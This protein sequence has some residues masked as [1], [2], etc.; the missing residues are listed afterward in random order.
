MFFEQIAVGQTATSRRIVTMDDIRAFAEVSGDRNPAHLDEEFAAK[1]A[2]KG[3]I[4][5]G[6]LSVSF[7]SALLAGE[8]PGAGSI[9]MGQSLKFLAPVRPGDEVLTQITVKELRESGKGRGEVVCETL[10]MVGD[11]VVIEGEALLMAPRE[12][13]LGT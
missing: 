8:L 6:M 10:C 1:T 11:K 13:K 5:H 3:V 4:A 9:Y 7:I 12:K 2:F